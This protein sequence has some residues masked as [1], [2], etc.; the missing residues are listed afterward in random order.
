MTNNQRNVTKMLIQKPTTSCFEKLK[1]AVVFHHHFHEL[2][3]RH[4]LYISANI[5]ERPN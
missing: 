2:Y 4:E 3:M 1:G 5:S